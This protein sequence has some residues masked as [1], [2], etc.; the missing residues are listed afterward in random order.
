MSAA[1][2]WVLISKAMGATQ[3]L[4]QCQSKWCVLFSLI[5]RLSCYAVMHYTGQRPLKGKAQNED[6]MQCWT[7]DDSYVLI[8]KWVSL[9]H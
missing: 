2:F 1:G 9:Y 5:C 8:C 7:E 4:K 6:Q 3:T